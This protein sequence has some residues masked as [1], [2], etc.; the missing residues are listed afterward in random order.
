MALTV[1]NKVLSIGWDVLSYAPNSLDYV[2]T[3]Y[4]FHWKNSLGG[5][6]FKT[7]KYIKIYRV[8]YEWTAEILDP[9]K[10][11][12]I[13]GKLVFTTVAEIVLHSNER[14]RLFYTQKNV[15]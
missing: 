2:I 12:K 1:R 11:R 6:K 14:C 9:E 7:T 10:K 5:I 4:F 13:I 15:L 3:T 8:V